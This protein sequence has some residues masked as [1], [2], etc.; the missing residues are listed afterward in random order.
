MKLYI[1]K[2]YCNGCQRLVSTRKQK[3]NSSIRVLCSRCGRVLRVW[4]GIVW[5]GLR[6]AA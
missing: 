3:A 4:N 1:K 2:I 6:E 5:R